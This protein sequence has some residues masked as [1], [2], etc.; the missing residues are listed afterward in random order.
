MSRRVVAYRLVV[1]GSMSLFA[2]AGCDEPEAETH[3]AV[4]A[5]VGDSAGITITENEAPTSIPFL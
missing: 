3:P 2:A 5:T 1:I 4:T